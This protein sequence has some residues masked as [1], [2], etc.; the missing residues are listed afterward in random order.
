[1][2]EWRRNLGVQECTRQIKKV[3]GVAT[4]EHK[5]MT[6]EISYLMTV[7]F[8]KGNSEGLKLLVKKPDG[9]RLQVTRR[10]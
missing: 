6:L 8:W 5:L 9:F 4:S 2:G 3:K 7:E 1:M 10:G